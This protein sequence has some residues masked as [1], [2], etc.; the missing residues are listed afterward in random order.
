MKVIDTVRK[1]AA[2]AVWSQG[3][4]LVRQPYAA[5]VIKR[6]DAE[7]ELRVAAPGHSVPLT[8]TIYFGDVEWSCNC[9]SPMDPCAHVVAAA[10]ALE[11][12]ERASENESA[13]P[14]PDSPT[15]SVDSSTS[16]LGP[17]ARADAAAVN[18]D[19]SDAPRATPPRVAS[20]EALGVTVGRPTN[21][22][23]ALENRRHLGYRLL[24]ESGVVWLTRVLVAPDGTETQLR[25]S[26]SSPAARALVMEIAPREQDLHLD[27]LMGSAAGKYRIGEAMKAVATVLEGAPDVRVGTRAVRVSKEPV[28]PIV[29]LS[30]QHG[31]LELRFER[32]PAIDEVIGAGLA[33]L[34]DELRPLGETERT[35]W[36]LERLPSARRFSPSQ[37]GELVNRILPELERKLIVEIKT[38]RLPGRVRTVKPHVEFELITEGEVLVARAVIVYGTPA[39]ARIVRGQLVQLGDRSPKRMPDAEKRLELALRDELDLL[40][41]RPLRLEGL[42]AARFVERLERWRRKNAST[43]PGAVSERTVEIVSE[44]LMRDHEPELVF[45][46]LGEPDIRVSPD[47]VLRAHL[48]GIEQL[49]LSDGSWG[50]LPKGWPF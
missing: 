24:Q 1:A 27:R 43:T 15:R 26:L 36:R 6:N 18:S 3:V 31:E 38:D 9:G 17:A 12:E 30:E 46:A 40:L 49:P 42:D 5:Q 8:V 4:R 13:S 21:A 35:G 45:H 33:R 16:E 44:L 23:R 22:A 25:V 34:G 19:A 14:L 41:D 39:L 50:I 11:N 47:V 2:S 10:I 37:S 48:E 20:P 7:A 29:T 28:M 32:D